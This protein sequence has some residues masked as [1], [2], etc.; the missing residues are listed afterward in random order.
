MHSL[1]GGRKSSTNLVAARSSQFDEFGALSDSPVSPRTQRDKDRSR[2]RAIS[3]SAGGGV[4]SADLSSVPPQDGPPL[5]G[6]SHLPDGAFFP[7]VIPP[8][9]P[10]SLTEYGYISAEADILLSIE[11]ALRL[12]AVVDRE[13]STRGAFLLCASL[14]KL[15]FCGR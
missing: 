11:D 7:T 2:K 9:K 12:V 14:S 15:P 8:K 6:Y 3:S 5:G 1:F 13:L 10:A 4:S